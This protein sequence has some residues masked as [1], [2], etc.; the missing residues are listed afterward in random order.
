MLP[1]SSEEIAAFHR[2]QARLPELFRRVTTDRHTPQTVVA[3]PSLSLDPEELAKVTGVHHY[4]ERMLYML[5]LL[6][7]PRTRLVYVTS[8]QIDP[9]II[10]YFLHLLTGIPS[11]HARERL[12]LLYC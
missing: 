6:R 5:M 1:G 12:T 3:I 7:R 2:L 10:D 9:I 4:E 11:S 8:Q